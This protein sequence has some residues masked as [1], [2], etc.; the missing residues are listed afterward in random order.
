MK[1]WKRNAVIVA[2]VL[3]VGAAVYLNW[4]YQESEDAGKTLG[5]AELV[6]GQTD[7]P[8]LA[9]SPSPDPAASPAPAEN[10]ASD[11]FASARLN[12]QQARD[13]ALSIL[14]DAA[15]DETAD[16]TV[17]AETAMAIQTLADYTVAEAQIEN[18]V[19]AK[20]YADCIAFISDNSVSVVVS[21][22]GAELT[23]ADVARIT[24]IVTGETGCTA[25]Q[26][27]IIQTENES[28]AS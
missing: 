3:F 12:R 9:A 7:D 24:E 23:D 21:S 25:D 10:A 22:G 2:V 27:K 16:E 15:A 14:Q 26:V 11:Y 5:Q 18:L 4:T 20:G 1:V 13:S 17:K 19:T 8:L 28:A 6:N